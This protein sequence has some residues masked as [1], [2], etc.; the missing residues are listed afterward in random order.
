[1]T[2]GKIL[3]IDAAMN[4]GEPPGVYCDWITADGVPHEWIFRAQ[5]LEPRTDFDRALDN[6]KQPRTSFGVMA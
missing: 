6:L 4:I 1:M 3:D 2:V 5:Q